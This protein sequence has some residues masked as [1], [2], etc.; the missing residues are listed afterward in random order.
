[1]RTGRLPV[2]QTGFRLLSRLFCFHRVCRPIVD[3]GF[4]GLGDLV[5]VVSDEIE[6]AA[7][8]EVG[9]GLHEME[10]DIILHAFEHEFHHPFIITEPG[11][12]TG[13]SAAGHF[14]DLSWIFPVEFCKADT[15]QHRFHDD[16]LV[17]DRQLQKDREPSVRFILIFTGT[18]D[19]DVVPS[20]APV[21]RKR[22]IEAVR[23]FGNE[24]EGQV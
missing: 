14:I 17:P 9:P 18:A 13:F 1:M 2:G 23:P 15:L 16:R 8:F 4:C 5:P 21:I 12:R 3:P 19:L 6:L 10:R 7:F 11:I 24:V 20:L 22:S